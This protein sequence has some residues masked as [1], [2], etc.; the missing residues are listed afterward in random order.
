MDLLLYETPLPEP[1][2]PRGPRPEAGKVPSPR[3]DWAAHVIRFAQAV[4][5]REGGHSVA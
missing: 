1:P 2:P 5:R 4:A 3:F